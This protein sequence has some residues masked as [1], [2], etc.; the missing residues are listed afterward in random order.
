MPGPALVRTPSATVR[1]VRDELVV[2][3]ARGVLG[4]AAIAADQIVSASPGRSSVERTAAYVTDPLRVPEEQ[5]AIALLREAQD[6]GFERLLSEQRAAWASRWADCD[7]V[8]DGDER[9]QLAVRFA[10]FHLI[11]M[12]CADGEAALGAR[13]ATGHAYNGH[14][15]WDVESFVLP[16]FAATHP[17]TARAMLNYRSRRLDAALEAARRQGRRGARFPWESATDGF[18]VT[19][20]VLPDAN[21]NPVR[22]MSGPQEEHVIADVAWG[23]AHYLDWT[24]DEQFARGDGQRLL[25]ETARYWCERVERDETGEAHIAGVMGP[26]EYHENVSDSAYTNVMARW[27]LRRAAQHVS[28]Y[29]GVDADEIGSW[30]AAADALV[31]GYDPA[32]GIYEEFSGYFQLEDLTP[33]DFGSVPVGLHSIIGAER[34]SASR[35]VKQADVVMAHVLADEEMMPGSFAADVDYY[36]PR[37]TA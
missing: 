19:P 2:A 1:P 24:G 8:I 9:A 25:V 3:S 20:A 27:N 22:I 4:G 12:C 32:R 15:F 23:A 35:A 14:V 31:D 26:D 17:P 7:V 10:M 21:G 37:T 18:D 30:L 34:C 28:R 13:S 11:S 16:F 33:G 36:L 6:G 29:G 5:E